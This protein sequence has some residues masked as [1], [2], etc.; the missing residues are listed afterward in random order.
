MSDSGREVPWREAEWERLQASAQRRQEERLAEHFQESLRLSQRG[1]G[2]PLPWI[3][4]WLASFPYHDCS[5]MS[6][7]DIYQWLLANGC[8]SCDLM[9][10]CLIAAG[11]GEAEEQTKSVKCYCSYND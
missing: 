7:E 1:H 2:N 11:I 3:N 9:V 10:D 4:L 5:D 6:R 8:E